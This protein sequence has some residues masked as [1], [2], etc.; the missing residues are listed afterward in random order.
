MHASNPKV[1]A[2]ITGVLA[3]DV[4]AGEL[5][6]LA[7]KRHADDLER[8]PAKDCDEAKRR[9]DPFWFDEDAGQ[10]VLDFYALCRH[11]EGE[12]AGKPFDPLP[13]QCFV[14][15]VSFGWMR[16]DTGARRFNERWIEVCR[17]NGKSYWMSANGDY[18]TLADGEPGAKVFGC[19]DG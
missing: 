8:W 9:G 12:L 4:C 14:D 6:R 17:G 5:V 2:Y 7:V 13:W 18:M 15:Y 3:G 10:Y 16:T 1:D 19:L 11:V